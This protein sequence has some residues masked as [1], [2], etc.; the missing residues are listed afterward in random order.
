MIKIKPMKIP[1]K[2]REGYVL[3]YHTIRSDLIG[4]DEFGHPIFE[5]KRT[6]IGELL[7]RLKY[8]SDKSILESIVETAADFIRSW[9]PKLKFILPTPSSRTRKAFQ[10]VMEVAKELSTRLN[11][12]LCTNCIV[13]VRATPEL[14][15]IY[16][17]HQRI[18]LLANAYDI[19]TSK[20]EN[21]N[22]LLFDDL[23]RSGAT[24]NAITDVL[25]TNGKAAN[26][27]VLALTRTKSTS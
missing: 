12:A 7:F 9:N 8:R 16:D 11:I 2:W 27:Y 6:E 26:V 14:K 20:L 23:Y 10:P 19:N 3:D 25:Y 17:Y 4:Y 22:I 1:G 24:L 13:K 15:N 21:H 18:E 5:T